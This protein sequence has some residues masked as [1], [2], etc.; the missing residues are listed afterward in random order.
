MHSQH[1]RQRGF[2]LVELMVVI[3]ILGLLVGVLA[4]AVLP[5]IFKARKE[6]ELKQLSDLH[7]GLEA[8]SAD[9]A[10]RKALTQMND[11]AGRA[12]WESCFKRRVLDSALLSKVVSLSSKVGD[13]T[14]DSTFIEDDGA[15]PQSGCSY[16]S[17]KARELLSTMNLR[18]S[19]KCAVITFDSRN[20]ENYREYGVPVVWSESGAPEYLDFA[21]ASD[22]YKISKEEWA[23]PD[24]LLG[25]KKPFQNTFEEKK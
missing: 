16:T 20:W 23:N 4:V 2:T 7:Q 1:S 5:Q 13:V 10:N 19:K 11:K 21:A 15:L 17:P 9:A 3:G 12:F 24:K 8:A 14:A 22:T 6:L 25:A 18:G